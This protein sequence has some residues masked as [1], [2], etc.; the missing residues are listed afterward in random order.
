[1]HRPKESKKIG[2]NKPG[3]LLRVKNPARLIRGG[4]CAFKHIAPHME[5]EER[6]LFIIEGVMLFFICAFFR[7]YASMRQANMY[8]R[9]KTDV[10]V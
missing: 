5:S 2:G 1:M 8:I 6:H 4:S 9:A 10:P 7:A 3:Y